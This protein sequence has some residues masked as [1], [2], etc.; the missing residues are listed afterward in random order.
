MHSVRQV[1][2]AAPATMQ[3]NETDL[4]EG[5]GSQASFSMHRGERMQRRASGRPVNR[6]GGRGSVPCRPDF[7]PMIGYIFPPKLTVF[8]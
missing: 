4:E 3:R 1:S 7:V 8:G 5:A 2:H 6:L